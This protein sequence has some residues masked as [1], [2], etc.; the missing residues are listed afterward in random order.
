MQFRHFGGFALEQLPR[1]LLTAWVLQAGSGRH[2]GPFLAFP[3][4]L[5][6]QTV[7]HLLP[8]PPVERHLGVMPGKARK[9]IERLLW[10]DIRV[11]TDRDMH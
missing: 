9:G 8:R 2:R 7:S 11:D 5:L 10:M 6:L 3:L 4:S 1:T